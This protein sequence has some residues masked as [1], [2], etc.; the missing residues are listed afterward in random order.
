MNI[1]LVGL[2]LVSSLIWGIFQDE[3]ISAVSGHRGSSPPR[4]L[5]APGKKD[6]LNGTVVLNIGGHIFMTYESVFTP[7]PESKL[8]ALFRGACKDNNTQSSFCNTS[9]I[10]ERGEIFLDRNPNYFEPILDFC[11]SGKFYLPPH[12]RLEAV[13][14]E[15]KFFGMHEYMFGKQQNFT[16]RRRATSLV[17]EEDYWLYL[18]D[19]EQFI[20]QSIEDLTHC[21]PNL[22]MDEYI[23]TAELI[24]SGTIFDGKLL[25]YTKG[26]VDFHLVF[27][28]NRIYKIY[29]SSRECL[30][31][32]PFKGFKLELEIVYT[33]NT[34]DLS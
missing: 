17:G 16:V 26:P 33:F 20:L 9:T 32:V 22:Q 4:G 8:G 19:N 1:Y 30:Y 31:N 13:E 15:A 28:G 21:G 29:S 11:R 23:H 18:P 27:P 25:A 7:F 34:T 12:I 10:N 5:S 6:D 3:I 14:E 2:C 24:S